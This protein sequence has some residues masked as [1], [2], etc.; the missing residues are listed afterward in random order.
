MSD[1]DFHSSY[2]VF[3]EALEALAA[4][5]DQ[6]C[7]AMGDFNVAWE[8]KDDVQAGKYLIGQGHLDSAQEAW[9]STLVCAL[10]AVP[11]NKLP[12][13]AGRE[14]NLA[15]MQ[16]PSWIPLR[17]LAAIALDALSAATAGNVRY[18]GLQ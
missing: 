4:G 10:D 7:E 1:L 8:L 11:A 2:R 17:V 18:L 15:A 14:S 9:I 6:Q 13:G 16:H 3:A 5:A 12:A